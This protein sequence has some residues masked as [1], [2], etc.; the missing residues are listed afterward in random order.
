MAWIVGALRDFFWGFTAEGE[1][2]ERAARQDALMD[3]PWI[4]M[5]LETEGITEDSLTATAAEVRG[6]PRPPR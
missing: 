2:A 5:L 4:R 3:D 6:D 1:A